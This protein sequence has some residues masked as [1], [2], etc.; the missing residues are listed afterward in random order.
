[1]Y[2]SWRQATC[3]AL[4][5][6][7]I[8][9]FLCNKSEKA[10]DIHRRVKLQFG[11]ACLS[12]FSLLSDASRWRTAVNLYRTC[13]MQSSAP[14]K[15]NKVLLFQGKKRWMQHTNVTHL[16]TDL[17]APT[18]T[19]AADS[20]PKETLPPRRCPPTYLLLSRCIC[21]FLPCTVLELLESS[22]S[23]LELRTFFVFVILVPVISSPKKQ[24]F[25]LRFFL[26]L[27][28]RVTEMLPVKIRTQD[29]FRWCGLCSCYFLA[30]TKSFGHC[31]VLLWF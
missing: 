22:L 15:R 5:Q 26:V 4:A 13:H 28:F 6:C 8:I 1:V 16:K 19:K 3:L 12:H 23:E 11:E 31:A 30:N 7:V 9:I 2:P 14:R 21:V 10:S 27:C 18:E 24:S 25:A 29:S 17:R 20:C